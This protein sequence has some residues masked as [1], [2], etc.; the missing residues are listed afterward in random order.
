M[1]KI[2]D[3]GG[4]QNRKNWPSVK[5]DRRWSGRLWS[6]VLSTQAVAL[7]SKPLSQTV[8]KAYPPVSPM[9]KHWVF[10][11]VCN[12]GFWRYL[13]PW[14]TKCKQ[15]QAGRRLSQEVFKSHKWWCLWRMDLFFDGW[16][17]FLSFLQPSQQQL[18]WWKT[19]DQWG[20]E[21]REP[22]L[23]SQT[24]SSFHNGH[25]FCPLQIFIAKC[26]WSWHKNRFAVE[27]LTFQVLWSWKRSDRQPPEV[28][29]LL[30]LKNSKKLNKLKRKTDFSSVEYGV[31]QGNKKCDN[32]LF[33]NFETA[34][35]GFWKVKKDQTWPRVLK[36]V[37]LVFSEWDKN[38][39]VKD[40]VWS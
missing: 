28:W 25:M 7:W 23:P 8:F 37:I 31:M 22:Q 34:E 3:G 38:K 14:S 30:V 19:A 6:I 10:C 40:G 4:L 12:T 21:L 26:F 39:Q 9:I 35:E 5:S 2:L 11:G 18:S 1:F 29:Q 15:W 13:Q 20:S 33:W 32:C 27:P 16:I 36:G 17:C 24:P